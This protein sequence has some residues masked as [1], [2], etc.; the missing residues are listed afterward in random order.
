MGL[1]LNFFHRWCLILSDILDICLYSSRI[2][3]LVFNCNKIVY[4]LIIKIHYFSDVWSYPE[5]DSTSR[6]FAIAVQELVHG[7]EP[8]DG[9][10]PRQQAQ[11]EME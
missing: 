8:T 9:S 6:E 10:P 1:C 11:G 4:R 2:L 3:F 7:L 5:T